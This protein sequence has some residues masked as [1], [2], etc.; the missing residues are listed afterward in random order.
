MGVNSLKGLEFGLLH[1]QQMP[2]IIFRRDL[3]RESVLGI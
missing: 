2:K 3:T 1:D